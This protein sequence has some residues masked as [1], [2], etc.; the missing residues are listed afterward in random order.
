MSENHEDMGQWIQDLTTRA[1]QEQMRSLQRYQDLMR[2][3]MS[4]ELDEQ[5]IREEYMRFSREETVRYTRNLATL[6][7]SYYNALADLNRTF[8]DRFFNQVLRTSSYQSESETAPPPQKV[9]TT[10]KATVGEVASSAFVIENKRTET[11]E[12]SFVVSEFMGAADTTPF[13][14]PLQI[15]PPRFTLAPNEEQAVRIQLPL[16]PELFSPGEMY[17]AVI[18]V[19]GYGDLE[20]HL[21]VLPEAAPTEIEKVAPTMKDDL[22]IIKGIGPKYA[23]QLDKAG[24]ATFAD[25]AHIKDT[26]LVE[27]LGKT[28]ESR[29]RTNQWRQQAELAAN[30]DFEGLKQLQAK[31]NSDKK[32]K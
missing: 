10:L 14:P 19:R 23:D 3:V 6:S 7:L 2:R 25:M 27:A 8:N 32:S 5:T 4:G 29:A 12:I 28:A 26:S 1:V 30:G 11:A 15:Q 17:S 13:R 21:R 22:T 20:L 9:E 18:V 16:L 24:V 31:L